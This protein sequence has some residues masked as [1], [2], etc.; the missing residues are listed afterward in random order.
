MHPAV[1]NGSYDLARVREDFP[2]LS[3]QV[4]GKRWSISTTPP[5]PRNRRWFWIA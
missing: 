5:R 4:H 3:M 2:I 1:F